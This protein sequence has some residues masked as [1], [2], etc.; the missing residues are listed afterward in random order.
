MN[1][2]DAIDRAVSLD[3]AAPA[4]VF[5]GRVTTYQEFHSILGSFTEYFTCKACDRAILSAYS[6]GTTLFTA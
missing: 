1:L 2:S 6:W 3:P 4:F 5:N